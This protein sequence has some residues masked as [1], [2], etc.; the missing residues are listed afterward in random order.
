MGGSRR[1]A[2][3]AACRFK[4]CC[5]LDG[6]RRLVLLKRDEVEHLVLLGV[7]ND[8]VIE[9]GIGASPEKPAADFGAML[10]GAPT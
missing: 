2:A 5:P 10:P 8:V 3:S 4:K 9:T 7:A 1:R 6:K